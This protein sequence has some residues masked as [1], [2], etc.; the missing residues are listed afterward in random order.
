MPGVSNTESDQSRQFTDYLVWD[1]VEVLT[2]FCAWL[3]GQRPAGN[4]ALKALGCAQQDIAPKAV[5]AG[6]VS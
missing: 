4:W 6:S 2:S 1:M 5:K 3:Y